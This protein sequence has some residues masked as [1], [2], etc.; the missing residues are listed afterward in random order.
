MAM[1]ASC[2]HANSYY[3]ATANWQT[4]YPRLQGDHRCYVAVVGAGF[5][6]NST[7]LHLLE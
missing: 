6:G 4:D 5:T 3:A 1:N 7:A 2:E